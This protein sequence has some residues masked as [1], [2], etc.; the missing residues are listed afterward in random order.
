MTLPAQIVFWRLR[1]R[2]ASATWVTTMLYPT[3]TSCCSITSVVGHPIPLTSAKTSW[4]VLKSQISTVRADRPITIAP[5]APTAGWTSELVHFDM[6]LSHTQAKWKIDSQ[7][8]CMQLKLNFDQLCESFKVKHFLDFLPN[9]S[10]Y[11][12]LWESVHASESATVSA[13][14]RSQHGTVVWSRVL[15]F[16][17]SQQCLCLGW[18]LCSPLGRGYWTKDSF[19]QSFQ[20]EAEDV[21]PPGFL[22]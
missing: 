15:F 9:C 17:G 12:A 3:I 19:S 20:A 14:L 5:S 8:E 10:R 21:P 22:L 16:L 1:V 7:S 13:V 18:Y 11:D 6:C 2:L 4:Y